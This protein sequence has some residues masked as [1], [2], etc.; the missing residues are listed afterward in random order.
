MLS[1][2]AP[3]TRIIHNWELIIELSK[4]EV[5]DRYKGQPLGAIWLFI[6]PLILILLYIFLFG[7]VFQ[8]NIGFSEKMPLSYASYILSG[9]VPWI[10]IQTAMS[11]G[12]F[13]IAGNSSFIKQVIFPV[14]VFPIKSMGSSL[15]VEAI[16]LIGTLIYNTLSSRRVL[17]TY[18]L[19]PVA[20]FLQILFLTGLNYLLS[21][22]AAYIRDLKDLVQVFCTLGVYIMPVLYLPDAVP[23]IFRPFL[24]I[25][26]FSHYIWMFQDVLYFGS[27]QHPV[28]WILCAV[29]SVLLFYF[30]DHVFQKLKVSFGSVV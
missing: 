2:K 6:H 8:S 15:I 25:N 10:C 28:S 23:A 16:Y 5:T 3:F 26:L 24:Y 20:I 17:W 4:R 12:V 19:L 14:E 27:I 21:S 1:I 7:I 29:F 30:G 9:V 13:S 22:L 18:L 11:Y